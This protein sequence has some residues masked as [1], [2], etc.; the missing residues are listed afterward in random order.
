M[1][2]KATL[3]V[4]SPEF[5]NPLVVDIP[6][7]FSV[8]FGADLVIT[9]DSPTGTDVENITAS[10]KV[11]GIEIVNNKL[12]EQFKIDLPTLVGHSISQIIV[13]VDAKIV[14]EIKS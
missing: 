1:Q 6:E 5:L 4:T 7:S 14:L 13:G 9:A 2:T 10:L 12:I 3:T 11:A 8:P